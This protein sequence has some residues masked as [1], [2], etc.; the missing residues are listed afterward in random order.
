MSDWP[1]SSRSRREFREK[2]QA[3]YPEFFGSLTKPLP[4]AVDMEDMLSD[5]PGDE[6]GPAEARKFLAYWV[7]R[8]EYLA[9]LTTR[10]RRYDLE[11]NACGEITLKERDDAVEEL[12]TFL[13]TRWMSKK[14]RIR[15]RA[16][17]RM[18]Y[19]D[20]PADVCRRIETIVCK[21][22]PAHEIRVLPRFGSE[23]RD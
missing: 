12:S 10:A 16:S 8:P 6:I 3:T 19:L 15:K 18:R 22:T 2:M 23:V 9:A 1:L 4:A 14:K 13:A 21:M 11:G 20:L 7:S 5:A 17:K